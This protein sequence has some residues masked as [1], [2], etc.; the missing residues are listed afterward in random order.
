MQQSDLVLSQGSNFIFTSNG[1]KVVK[2]YF[3]KVEIVDINWNEIETL[4][5]FCNE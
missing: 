5:E 1:S 3:G 2:L 4:D